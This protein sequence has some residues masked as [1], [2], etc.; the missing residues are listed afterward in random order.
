MLPRVVASFVTMGTIDVLRVSERLVLLL[1]TTLVT[2]RLGIPQAMDAPGTQ[3]GQDLL[4]VQA[5]RVV[6]AAELSSRRLRRAI[7]IQVMKG[8][9]KGAVDLMC[10]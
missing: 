9:M 2:H 3:M 4:L 8:V 5:L 7:S 6:Q 10:V 1:V